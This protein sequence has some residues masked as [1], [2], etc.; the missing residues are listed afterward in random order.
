MKN[1]FKFRRYTSVSCRD[2]TKPIV[3]LAPI[4]GCHNG[5]LPQDGQYV[6]GE[7]IEALFHYENAMEL[8]AMVVTELGIDERVY[9]VK[10]EER[11]RYIVVPFIVDEIRI[12]RKGSRNKEIYVAY[13]EQKEGFF[14]GTRHCF[15]GE[16]LQEHDS[17]THKTKEDAERRAWALNEL[18]QRI[19]S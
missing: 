12:T 13:C 19:Q 18:W 11:G 10:E 7:V 17:C 15:E 16:R 5:M 6:P 9:V 14:S 3:P 4:A 8:K 1:P 2:S